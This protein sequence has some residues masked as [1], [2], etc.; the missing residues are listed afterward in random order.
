MSHA[1]GGFSYPF[2]YRG[3]R[4]VL[5]RGFDP[6]GLD[7]LEKQQVTFL[8]LVPTM[9]YFLV[10]DAEGPPGGPVA[11]PHHPLYG[12]SPIAPDRAGRVPSRSSAPS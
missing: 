7:A 8:L 5:H 4:R 11:D 9:I 1:S 2:L 12:G 10:E 3:G 6:E